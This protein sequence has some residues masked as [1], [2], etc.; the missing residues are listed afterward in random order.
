MLK[1]NN[2]STVFTVIN[3]GNDYRKTKEIRLIH[4]KDSTLDRFEKFP[5][6]P[7]KKNQFLK[8]Q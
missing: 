7:E 6:L 8:S 2:V 3:G 4:D 5:K 1:K